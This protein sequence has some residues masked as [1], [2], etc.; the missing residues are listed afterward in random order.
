[1][2]FK[3]ILTYLTLTLTFN[4]I[5]LGAAI[6]L[7]RNINTVLDKLTELGS[8]EGKGPFHEADSKQVKDITVGMGDAMPKTFELFRNKKQDFEGAYLRGVIY[9]HLKS[10]LTRTESLADALGERMAEKDRE[11]MD[12]VVED[13]VDGYENVID[14]FEY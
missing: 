9:F 11:V 2:F 1:M 7:P 4:L 6:A 14:E 10:L 5:T 3:T 13:V 12:G 8:L